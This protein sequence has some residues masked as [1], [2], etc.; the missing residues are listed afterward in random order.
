MPSSNAAARQAES[1]DSDLR[2]RP[3]GVAD[4]EAVLR[5]ERAFAAPW[6]REMFV[7]ELE[8]PEGS[9]QLVAEQQGRVIG[10]VLWWCVA[11]EVHV[12]NLAVHHAYR[13]RGVARRLLS[14]AFDAARERGL[15]IA[16]LEVRFHNAAAIA[17][18][19]S[20]GFRKIAIRKAYYADNG[21]DA[22]VMLKGLRSEAQT[23]APG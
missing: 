9:A 21:E 1:P 4:L 18:Y 14:A 5:I 20:L 23:R 16:T 22:L 6:T 15:A 17:L 8:Q 2:L 7:Q 12:V 19:E 11:D 3:M 13:R 10:Y